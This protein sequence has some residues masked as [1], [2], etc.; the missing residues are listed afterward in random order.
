VEV[1]PRYS[2]ASKG[3]G[4]TINGLIEGDVRVMCLRLHDMLDV[5]INAEHPALGWI[6]RHAGW[7]RIRF[8]VHSDGFTSYQSLRGPRLHRQDFRVR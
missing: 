2:S 6:I 5:T 4:E 7:L 8:A 3:I 1:V